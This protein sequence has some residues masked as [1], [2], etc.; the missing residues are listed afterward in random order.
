M[1]WL[2]MVDV[3]EVM[4][5]TEK[6][7]VPVSL[8]DETRIRVCCPRLAHKLERIRQGVPLTLSRTHR[9]VRHPARQQGEVRSLHYQ[10]LTGEVVAR[11]WRRARRA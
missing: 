11:E 4:D 5:G 9:M 2:D 7:H 1:I 3:M 10:R 6:R 8:K